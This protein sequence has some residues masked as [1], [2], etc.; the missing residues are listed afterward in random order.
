M[1]LSCTGTENDRDETC[2]P[3]SD[4]EH[5]SDAESENISNEGNEAT[6]EDFRSVGNPST[7]KPITVLEPQ[8]HVQPLEE[9][10]S[11]RKCFQ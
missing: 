2:I 11:Y 7:D 6:T 4:E 8:Y 10:T 9:M 5:S 1:L 3:E